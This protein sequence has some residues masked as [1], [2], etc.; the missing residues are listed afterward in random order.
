MGEADVFEEVDEEEPSDI[1]VN[2][3]GQTTYVL[4]AEQREAFENGEDVEM[5]DGTV[6]NNADQWVSNVFS[7]TGQIF[8]KDKEVGK[9]YEGELYD[10]EGTLADG[11]RSWQKIRR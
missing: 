3:Q 2:D 11:Q 8:V 9:R 4:N 5:S 7:A 6:I 10:P 1:L